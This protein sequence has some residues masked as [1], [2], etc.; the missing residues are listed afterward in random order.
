MENSLEPEESYCPAGPVVAVNPFSCLSR[1][2]ICFYS[3]CPMYVKLL[4]KP[5]AIIFRY[6]G[7]KT[8]Y[9]RSNQSLHPT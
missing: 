7:M 4:R 8:F 5:L 2:F 6:S 1:Y 3:S 9:S